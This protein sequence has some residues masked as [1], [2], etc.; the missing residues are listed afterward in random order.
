MLAHLPQKEKR[1][2]DLEC[3]KKRDWKGQQIQNNC[4]N[5]ALNYHQAF[6]KL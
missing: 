6:G 5:Q 2:S 1:E 3:D 4:L